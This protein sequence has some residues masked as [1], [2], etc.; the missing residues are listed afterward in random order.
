MSVLTV[1]QQR[2]IFR[3]ALIGLLI[4]LALMLL[5]LRHYDPPLERGVIIAFGAPE[6]MDDRTQNAG[7][8][9]EKITAAASE[10]TTEQDLETPENSVTQRPD[11]MPTDG[12]E[13]MAER[14]LNSTASEQIIQTDEET[15]SVESEKKPEADA[16]TQ[17]AL[18]RILAGQNTLNQDKQ[19]SG[20]DEISEQAKGSQL[21]DEPSTSPYDLGIGLDGD[22]NYL[23]GGRRAVHKE[24]IVQDCNQAGRVVV[25]IEVNQNG[26]VVS[27]MPGVRGTT[28][29]A[30]CLLDPAKRAALATEFNSDSRAP[31]RQIGKIIYVFRLSE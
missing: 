30:S 11:F 18:K 10:Q 21:S 4:L 25:S 14:D 29:N 27:A 28:N 15:V 20:Q 8:Q 2:G 19:S 3:T 26:Q 7:D 6:A 22:G 31:T 17:E 9:S 24:I 23:L 13:P 16:A 12:E 5:G 1:H